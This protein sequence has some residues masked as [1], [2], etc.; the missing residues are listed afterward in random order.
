MKA[1]KGKFVLALDQGTTS[2][3]AIVFDE[4]GETA[5][6]AQRELGQIY[7]KAGWVEHD[8]NEIISSVYYV[9]HEVVKSLGVDS[10]GI[11]AIGI[12][13]QRETVVAWD[14]RTGKP[15]YNA[16]VWQCRRSADECGR[17]IEA[18]CDKLIYDKTGLMPD[19]Y[20]SATKIKWI[21]DNVPAAKEAEKAGSLR[22]GTIDTYLMY[23]LSGGGIY[24]T[25][26]TNA[27]R[28]MLFN[29]HKKE[30]DS[31]LLQLFAVKRE[32]LPAVYPSGHIYGVI[33]KDIFGREVPVCAVMGDQQSALFGQR[34]FSRGAMKCTFGTGCFLLCNTGGESVA[35]KRGLITTLA[36]DADGLPCYALEGSVFT[37]G[38]AVQWL[39]DEMR[40]ISSAAESETAAL[41]VADSGGVYVVPAFVGLG[42]PYWDSDARGTICGITRGTSREHIIRATLESIAYQCFDV[43][44]AIE[45]DTG[46]KPERLTV[47]GG[48]CANNLLMQFL[49]D[50][51]GCE[52]VRP[53]IIETTALGAAMLAARTVGGQ[54]AAML[55]KADFID[56]VFKPSISEEKRTKLVLG[57][58]RAVAKA[59]YKQ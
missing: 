42:A 33:G 2:T 37:G 4:Q 25:D 10:A 17:L 51:S 1:N 58:K 19:A 21:L 30:W 15:L 11:E 9:L 59:R 31:D 28:T 57:W 34:C 39:R 16:I 52:L 44:H 24:A 22:F 7:P 26:Y 32:T 36:A 8:P 13:N 45:R 12:T 53:H 38:S 47:D 14:E 27:S 5:A 50:I 46:I 54:T 20:F 49:A 56:R 3:R 41:K 40:I 29:I 18:G 48:A 43:I 55:Q 35:S 6:F 23:I